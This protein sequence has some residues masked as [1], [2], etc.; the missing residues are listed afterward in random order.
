MTYQFEDRL[1]DILKARHISQEK[2]AD[3]LGIARQTVS[4]YITGRTKPDAPALFNMAE[5]LQVSC[6]YLLGLSDVPA[7]KEDIQGAAKTTGLTSDAVDVLQMLKKEGFNKLLDM[8][9][10]LLYDVWNTYS[11]YASSGRD[12]IEKGKPHMFAASI[13]NQMYDYIS[14]MCSSSLKVEFT[15]GKKAVKGIAATI[16]GEGVPEDVYI[17]SNDISDAYI[18]NKERKMITAISMLTSRLLELREMG[19]E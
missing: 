13:L 14:V 10:L 15:D 6:D 12:M 8:I 9:E 18:Y 16:K 5:Y 1:K 11:L 2:L 19:S 3:A 4:S 17:T 7:I